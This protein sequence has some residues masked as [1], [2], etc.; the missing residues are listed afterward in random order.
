MTGPTMTG[1]PRGAPEIRFYLP[2]EGLRPL[3]TSYYFLE[4][5]GPLDDFFA[6]VAN[7]DLMICND[8]GVM[9]IAAALGVP[10]LSFH[11]LGRPEEWAPR[12]E[13]AIALHGELIAAITVDDAERAAR[14]LL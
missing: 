14:K 11:S 4:S 7:V 12:S 2:S 8:S 10:V 13:T 1:A 9:H 3:V 5:A 6:P